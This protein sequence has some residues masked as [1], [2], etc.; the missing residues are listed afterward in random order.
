MTNILNE[1]ER[2]KGEVEKNKIG[3]F[4]KDNFLPFGM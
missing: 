2:K 4:E 3:A 1:K